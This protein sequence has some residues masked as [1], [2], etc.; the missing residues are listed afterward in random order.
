[1]TLEHQLGGGDVAAILEP[2]RVSSPRVDYS[3]PQATPSV[4]DVLRDLKPSRD[5]LGFLSRESTFAARNGHAGDAA[6]LLLFAMCLKDALG[7]PPA[8]KEGA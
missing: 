2:G 1:M 5:L 3:N 4:V 6:A 8:P 7:Q